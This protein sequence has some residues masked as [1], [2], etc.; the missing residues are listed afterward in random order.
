MHPSPRLQEFAENLK[1]VRGVET[2]TLVLHLTAMLYNNSTMGAMMRRAPPEV[3]RGM[4]P[5]LCGLQEG[6]LTALIKESHAAVAEDVR[7]ALSM[8]QNDCTDFAAR[9]GK[10]SGNE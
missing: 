4:G 1:A 6:M 9:L 3:I 2:S 7:T 10:E 5:L 8:M